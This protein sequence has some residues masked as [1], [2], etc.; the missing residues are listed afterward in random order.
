MRLIARDGVTCQQLCQS[1]N[2]S[3]RN[4]ALIERSTR[5]L[6]IANKFVDQ[7]VRNCLGFFTRRALGCLLKEIGI[8]RIARNLFGIGCL[9]AKIGLKTSTLGVGQLGNLLAA[10]LDEGV[11]QIKRGQVGIGEQTIIV[12]RLFHAHDHRALAAGL[13]MA[14]LLIDDAALFEHLG[15]TANLVGK[16]IMQALERVE[17]LELGLGTQLG[18][19]T[20]TKTHI[21]IAAHG[22]LLHGAIGDAQGHKD[23]TELFHKQACFLGRAQVG[24]GH[25]LNERR[26]AAVVIDE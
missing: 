18:L 14:S 7:Q 15:L 11:V 9:D 20:A 26:A 25:E 3:G 2:L 5:A 23:A 19:A 10:V 24:F 1:G 13:P 4:T 16:A 22:A 6:K 8:G 17:V 21:A 12:G